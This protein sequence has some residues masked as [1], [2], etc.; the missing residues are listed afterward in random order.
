[1]ISWQ[2]RA[3]SQIK[4]EKVR[5]AMH[6]TLSGIRHDLAK[7]QGYIFKDR[8]DPSDAYDT[9]SLDG[10]GPSTSGCWLRRLSGRF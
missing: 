3:E 8:K 9:P 1:M 2:R 6:E 5:L 10:A 4:I 7:V